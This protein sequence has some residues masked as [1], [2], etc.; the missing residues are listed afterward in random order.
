MTKLQ[1][2]LDTFPGRVYT[3]L[4][5]MDGLTVRTHQRGRNLER[6]IL[7]RSKEFDAAMMELVEA[8]LWNERWHSLIYLMGRGSAEAF[9]PLYIGKAEKRGARNAISANL[10]NLRTNHGFFARWGYNTDYHIGDLSHALFGFTAYRAPTRKYRRWA[11]ALF[12]TFDPPVLRAPVG[13]LLL[14]W[15]EGSRGPSGLTGSV[16]SVEKEII[17]LASALNPELLN[18]DGR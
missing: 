1:T 11:D 16:A 6:R 13:M 10:R 9:T 12:V 14:P 2:W 3:P 8:G 5:D 4:F 18:V 7:T 17:A 15:V